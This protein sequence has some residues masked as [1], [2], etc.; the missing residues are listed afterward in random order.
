[1]KT[2]KFPFHLH[3]ATPLIPISSVKFSP[4]KGELEDKY[5]SSPRLRT[6]D[7]PQRNA[8]VSERISERLKVLQ[9]KTTNALTSSED[10]PPAVPSD[11]DAATA[12][13]VD[14][15]KSRAVEGQQSIPSSPI[16]SSPT[17]MS[18]MLPPR[19]VDHPPGVPAT[20]PIILA[21]LSFAPSAVSQL[22]LRAQA[23]LPLK[24]VRFPLIGEY[25]ESFTGEEFVGWLNENVPGFGRNLDRAEDAARELTEREGLLRRLGELGN[26]FEQ[27]DEAFY[28]FRPKVGGSILV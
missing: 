9:K 1:L 15:G 14:K 7:R 4:N 28:Q 20:A 21:G 26:Q 17:P 2:S 5:T 12:Q 19:V 8:T 24:P 10:A 11:A 16:L 23:E 13:R 3:V 18:P 6:A 25:Q 27:S 22:L